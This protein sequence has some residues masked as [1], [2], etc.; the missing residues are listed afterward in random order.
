M[1]VN[2]R[3]EAVSVRGPLGGGLRARAARGGVWLAGGGAAE[4]FGRLA[5]N[6]L[7]T[8]LLAPGAF[9]TMAIVLSLSSLV[10][11]MT[12]VGLGPAVIQHP[13]GGKDNYLNAAWWMGMSRAL[14]VYALIFASSPWFSQFYGDRDISGLLRVA[15]L[16][17]IFDGLL[18][19]RSKLIQKEMK[20]SR[21]AIITN[22]GALCG[23]FLTIVLALA[24]RNV[25]ALAIGYCSENVFRCLLSFVLCPGLPSTRWDKKAFREIW[26]F[27]RGMVGLSFLN[28][29]F[30]RADIFVLG[31]MVSPAEL[32]I[33][34]MG[35]YL[36]QTPSNFLMNILCS[37]LLPTLAHVQADRHRVNRVVS[38]AASWI[39]LTGLPGVAMVCLC[40]A[41]LM[42]VTYGPRYAPAAG[43]VALAA[44][45]ALL[46]ILNSLLTTV[47]F[48]FGKPE[49]HRRAVAASA[50]VMLIVIYPACKYLG[51]AG[52][53][54]AALSAIATS[55]VL[56]V[57]RSHQIT[58]LSI[59]HCARGVVPAA[60]V[61]AGM[62]LVGVGTH[63][64]GLGSQPLINIGIATGTCAIAYLILMP[65]FFKARVAA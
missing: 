49:L 8:R 39:T 58:G 48:A 7:L 46:N 15:L 32:G 64:L 45:V 38:E 34:T 55:Y 5:R 42:T 43:A 29:V 51:P 40:G 56:Q 3:S 22:G 1:T 13:H 54:L 10:G 59:F 26:E 57:T 62:I 20:F 12:D 35:V 50:V 28:L 9:G 23:V 11:S 36:I 53:Q 18:S 27:S 41:S 33:Y 14:F 21:W 31:K 44:G 4:Q 60:M 30:A 25:W 19:P 52:G 37:T 24:F 47:F 16:G 63:L 17:T 2:G 6:L 61:S 65:A